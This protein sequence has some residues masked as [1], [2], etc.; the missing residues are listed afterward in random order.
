MRVPIHIRL[1]PELLALTDEYAE[2]VGWTRTAVIEQALGDLL[3]S[4]L[5]VREDEQAR[6]SRPLRSGEAP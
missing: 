6:D 1:P 2:R 3:W 5:V 4:H